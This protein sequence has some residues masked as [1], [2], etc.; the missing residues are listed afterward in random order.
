MYKRTFFLDDTGRFNVKF[1]FRES[2][3]ELRSSRDLAIHRLQQ[4][5]RRF[6]KN[7]S[8]SKQY[9]KF[10]DKYQSKHPVPFLSM[11]NLW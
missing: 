6:G 4:I 7:E 9:H 5:E 3:D 1:L 10:M 8:L 11:T 2:S